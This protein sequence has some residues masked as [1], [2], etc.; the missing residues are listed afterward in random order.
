MVLHN[1]FSSKVTSTGPPWFG[2][3]LALQRP[4]LLAIPENAR[5]HIRRWIGNASDSRRPAAYRTPSNPRQYKCAT[6]STY[7]IP[8]TSPRLGRPYP[9]AF[10]PKDTALIAAFI[11]P[12][13]TLIDP[14]VYRH[15]AP[16][17]PGI[18]LEFDIGA[19][20]VLRGSSGE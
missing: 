1:S 19:S 17:C 7:Q 18:Q 20:E 10:S 13:Y 14:P 12:H 4:R 6:P 15:F 2:F 8:G 9:P 5:A 3:H 16:T 11:F